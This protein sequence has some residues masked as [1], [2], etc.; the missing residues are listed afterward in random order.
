M[1]IGYNIKKM[2]QSG[3]CPA[4]CETRLSLKCSA[5]KGFIN[6]ASKKVLKKKLVPKKICVKKKFQKKIWF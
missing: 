2:P 1:D 4:L 6:F 3:I 5:W